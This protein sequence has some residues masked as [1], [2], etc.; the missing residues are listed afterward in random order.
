MNKYNRS[1]KGCGWHGES[2]RHSLAAKGI[3]TK[4]HSRNVN[5][6]KGGMGHGKPD[7]LFDKNQL[8]KGIKVEMEHTNNPKIA[9]E[10][11]KD[12]LTE[13]KG[14]PYYDYLA[15]MEKQINIEAKLR[16][17]QKGSSFLKLHDITK[18]KFGST[19]WQTAMSKNIIKKIKANKPLEDYEKV[20]IEVQANRVNFASEDYKTPEVF[21]EP[22][23]VTSSEVKPTQTQIPV[24]FAPREITQPKQIQA[25]TKIG[26]RL[27][28]GWY[29]EGLKIEGQAL[30]NVGRATGKGLKWILGTIA[31]G[32]WGD[33]D[34]AQ[35][36]RLYSHC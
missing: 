17:K 22:I 14:Q 26:R 4:M 19:Q 31:E 32:G 1:Y 27:P 13:F 23:T 8:A 9:K 34:K 25:P 5:Y 30:K 11:V 21:Y 2:H 12:H 33:I 7:F 35:Y 16:L 18:H 29:K 24:K 36:A 28:K 6:M 15:K 20:F 10:I 3:H